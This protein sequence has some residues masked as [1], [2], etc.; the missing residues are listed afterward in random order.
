MSRPFD[1]AFDSSGNLWV[2]DAGNNRVDELNSS[3]A[4]LKAIGWGVSDGVSQ[5]ETCTVSC[6]AGLSGSGN[7]QLNGNQG[8]DIDGSGNLYVADLGNCR[9]QE[10]SSAGAF[11]TKW[12]R[13]GGT[14]A[15]GTGAGQFQAPVTIQLDSS[16]HVWVG[17][18]NSSAVQEFTSSGAYLAT[19]GGPGAAPGTF[20]GPQQLAFDS[21]GDLLVADSLNDRIELLDPADGSFGFAWGGPSGSTPGPGDFGQVGGVAVMPNNQV[22][23]SDQGNGRIELFTFT[24]PSA[25]APSAAPAATH[26]ALG[27][28]VDPGGGAAA[29][30]FVWGPTSAYGDITA[31]GGTGPGTGAQGVAST[32][33][34]LASATTYHFALI[35]SNPAG[36]STT[37]DQT[38][39]TT[40]PFGTGPEGP[41]GTGGPE[42]A[43]GS[44]GSGGSKGPTGQPGSTGNAGPAGAPGRNAT[45]VCGKPKL[46]RKKVTVTC[47][48]TLKLPARDHVSVRLSRDGRLYATARTVTRRA[49][50]HRLRL[51]VLRTPGHGRYKLT[52]TIA[53][54]HRHA[55]SFSWK[56]TL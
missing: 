26:A 18:F 4:F 25:S 5:L 43:D 54:G 41:Q 44:P 31:A 42:G 7:G 28:T 33:S 34:G 30:H 27:G 3:G 48:L 49:G 56:V 10:L 8:L 15:C 19:V 53:A 20:D 37:L 12:G 47:T 35:A 17:D 32:V 24:A 14:G 22:A 36:S 39:T 16:G 13:S 11:I 40:T 29:F 38:F 21:A 1:L 50:V 51:T 46:K 2:A 9:V 52:V 23:V 45:V 55:R 6:Q